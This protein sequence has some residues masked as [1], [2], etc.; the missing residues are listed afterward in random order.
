MLVLYNDRCRIK[1]VIP[2]KGTV[3]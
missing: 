2:F 1:V 3:M